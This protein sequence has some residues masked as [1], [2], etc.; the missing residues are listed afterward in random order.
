MDFFK[1]AAYSVALL[2]ALAPSK[3]PVTKK[4]R[5]TKT[6]QDCVSELYGALAL[7][8][9]AARLNWKFAARRRGHRE[10]PNTPVR[11]L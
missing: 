4:T 10:L 7:I 9:P 6:I 8:A 11:R 5:R 3:K 1:A 2:P